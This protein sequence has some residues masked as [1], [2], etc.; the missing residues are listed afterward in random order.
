MQIKINKVS[1]LLFFSSL[2]YQNNER[3]FFKIDKMA[4]SPQEAN[5]IAN[6]RSEV[7]DLKSNILQLRNRVDSLNYSPPSAN[8]STTVIPS[9]VVEMTKTK[10]IVL[11]VILYFIPITILFLFLYQFNC[12][13]FYMILFGYLICFALGILGIFQLFSF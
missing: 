5:K 11:I 3:I 7:L 4:V 12:V 6:L 8:H 1:I 13:P 10:S 9:S 2:M